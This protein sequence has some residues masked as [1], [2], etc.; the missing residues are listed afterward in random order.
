MIDISS[1]FR[2]YRPAA[3]VFVM[4]SLFAVG[5][6]MDLAAPVSADQKTRVGAEPRPA[7]GASVVVNP[8]NGQYS[9][10]T[11]AFDAIN[12]GTHTGAVTITIFSNTT[13][14]GSAVLNSSGAGAASYSTLLI[15]PGG[16]NVSISGPSLQGRGLIE[17]NG[18]DN[19]TIDGDNPN[20]PGTNKDLTIQNTAANTV[21][22]TS[23]IRVA[24]NTT[25]VTTANDNRIRNLNIVGSSTGQNISTATSTTGSANTTFGIF[26]GP[27]ASGDVT[28]PTAITS[29]TTGVGA[30]ATASGFEIDNNRIV[31][32]ARGISM[33]ASA[34]T[35][36]G[37]LDIFEN[38]IGNP[39]AGDVDQVTAAGITIG[40]STDALINENTIYVE[41]YIPSSA[42]NHGIAVGVLSS[43]ATAAVVERNRVNRVK[44][45]NPNTWSAYGV[46][47]GGGNGHTV[48]NNFI[49][50][51]IN[52]QT[53]GTG[54]FGTTFGAYGIRIAAGNDHFIYH[55]SVHLSGNMG[56]TTSTN[57]TAAFVVISNLRTGID[58]RNNLFSN[59]IAGGNPAGTRN[60][61]VYLPPSGTATMNLTMNN[62]GMFAGGDALNTL[63]QSGTAFA[64]SVN[65][66]VADFNPTTTT[67]ATNLRAYTSTLSAAGTNDNAS[68]AFTGAP[69]F[70]S[71]TDLHIPDSTA[72][73]LESRGTGVS[74]G[75]DIDGQA[76]NVTTPDI[77]ADEFAGVFVT[78]FLPPAQNYTPFGN[79]SQTGNRV[80]TMTVT[81]ETGVATAGVLVPRIYYR[82]N[83]GSYAATPCV[84]TGGTGTNGTWDCTID[85]ALLGGVALGDTVSYFT[86]AQDIAVPPN[87]GTN[88]GGGT[89]ADVTTIISPP[90]TPNSYLIVGALPATVNVGTG[91]AITSLT[92]AGGL[93]EALNSGFTLAGN[94][95][96]LITSDLTA[97]T[98]AVG[99][100]EFAEDGPGG[101]TLTIRPS[102]AA[103]VISG[104]GATSNGLINLNGTD[105][106]VIDG[107]L[108]PGGTTRD[109]TITNNQ[110]GTSTVIWMKTIGTN[111]CNN[112]VIRNTIINGAAIP[113][114]TT[115]A[116]ILT[117]SSVTIGN[118]GEGPQNNNTIQN[119]WIYRV[120]NSLYV[121]GGTAANIDEGWT[122]IGNTLGSNETNDNNIFRGMLIGNANNFVIANN[123]VNGVRSTATTT[124][125]MSGIQV[126]LLSTNGVVANNVIRNIKN[127]SSSGTGAFGISVIATSTASNVSITNNMIDDIGATGSATV[128]SNG[129]GISITGGSGWNVYYN[130]VNMGTNQASGTTS[131]M[132]V[133]AA[134][135]AAGAVNARNNIFANTQTSGATRYSVYSLAPA[136][137]FGT[138]NNNNYFSAE[139]VGFIGGSAR[140]TLG[141][142]QTATTQDA[143]SL[144]VNPLFVSAS[145]LHITAGSPM[146]GAAAPIAGITTDLDG[147]TRDAATPD[148]GADEYVVSEPGPPAVISGQVTDAGQNGLA[149]VT[150]TLTGPAFGDVGFTVITNSFGR[151]TF[152][153]VPTNVTYTVTVSH[154]RRYVFA[155]PSQEINLQGDVDNVNFIGSEP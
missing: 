125:A 33:N 37:G 88:P 69:P 99:L 109:L 100:N 62:N 136:S 129:H 139:N 150:V 120:Q 46:N 13:E 43:T 98:G 78:D 77:G 142:W 3:V 80:L 122:I 47:L 108:T 34:A 121:R 86:I 41:G 110:T 52:D 18:A 55:N 28:A 42:A 90:P 19:V 21:T 59:Q 39:V 4:A 107:S 29:V 153:A 32:A 70:V 53:T 14:P 58:V 12:A 5:L 81:D 151:F 97:E 82:K 7:F 87:I 50:N 85:V 51:I 48:R 45:N 74:V 105:R 131:A 135:T 143:N 23:V 79:T 118:D 132:F 84:L 91:E 154:P 54:G 35:V 9:T 61:V 116:G 117:G 127:V 49:S 113:N 2:H 66:T 149:F 112:N 140:V 133:S 44:N 8:G 141:D 146:I 31:T 24:L 15:Q 76:R 155:N 83:A 30:G 144:A 6:T 95:T 64:T 68:F 102:G 1:I 65:F 123:T 126:G 124:A 137:I 115:T 36:L 60:T 147:Q 72:T 73:P 71:N 148:I 75:S 56:G 38:E 63:G 96:I 134:V 27:N 128:A 92:N 16:D 104:S 130:S 93:F 103:R 145:D 11:A 25:T 152:P 57:L 67:P 94:T 26:L 101:Y 17:L 22:F 119:N 40:G 114:S 111:G 106:L 138:I 89:A 10:L 20:T